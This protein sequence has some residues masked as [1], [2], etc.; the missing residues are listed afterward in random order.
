MRPNELSSSKNYIS[1]NAESAYQSGKTG[2]VNEVKVMFVAAVD[3]VCVDKVLTKGFGI[4]VLY[5]RI[6]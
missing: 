4:Y 2:T 1:D 6:M 3:T 5:G